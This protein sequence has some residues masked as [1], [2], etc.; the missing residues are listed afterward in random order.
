MVSSLVLNFL[1]GKNVQINDLQNSSFKKQEKSNSGTVSFGAG[2]YNS[3]YFDKLPSQLFETNDMWQSV[4]INSKPI[5]NARRKELKSQLENS[6]SFKDLDKFTQNIDKLASVAGKHMDAALDKKTAFS[7]VFGNVSVLVALQKIIS[8]LNAQ[9]NTQNVQA[10]SWSKTTVKLAVQAGDKA[11]S[12]AKDRLIG[13]VS[14]GGVSMLMQGASTFS[15]IKA[16]KAES[17]SITNNL[18]RSNTISR[19]LQESQDSIQSCADSMIH[20]GSSLESNIQA[21]MSRAH[22][23]NAFESAELRHNH[24]KVTNN[25]SKVRVTSDF[26]NQTANSLH[27]VIQ[28]GAEIGAAA[29]IK[30][31]DLARA[32]QTI[33][34]NVEETENRFSKKFSD[35]E[36]SVRQALSAILNSSNEAVSFISG[37]MA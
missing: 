35:S 4:P 34:N 8:S 37:R 11:I 22:P 23:L 12:A 9:E 1:P 10:A 36:S 32:N 13:S 18:G 21:T 20:Q 17:N 16:L 33:S 2:F 14:A 27:S 28:S 15:S 5:S 31:S 26:I 25:T 6:Q 3:V 7:N 29:K 24:M 30:E 19:E